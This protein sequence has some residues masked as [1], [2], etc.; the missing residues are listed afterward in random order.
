M[1]LRRRAG[2]TK[3]PSPGMTIADVGRSISGTGMGIEAGRPPRAPLGF[4]DG[5]EGSMGARRQPECPR[6]RRCVCCELYHMAVHSCTDDT[7]NRRTAGA[8]DI[9]VRA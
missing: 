4:G 1:I 2:P 6:H 8:A 9:H 7:E 5:E 3:P